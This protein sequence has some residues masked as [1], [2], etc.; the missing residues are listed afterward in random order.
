MTTTEDGSISHLGAAD[1]DLEPGE[2]VGE[3]VVSAK[4]GEGGFGSVFRAEHPLIGK[5]VAIK[6]L[7]RQYSADPAMVQRF[8]AEARAVNQIRHRNIID[9]FSFGRLPDGRH[10]YVME[11]LDG[12][13]LDQ[14]V[15]ER[16]RIPLPEAV[17]ILRGVARALDAAHAKGIAHR[18]L[19]PENVFLAVDEQGGV[20]PKLLD[21]GIAKLLTTQGEGAKPSFKTRTGAPIG[22][23]YYMSPEQCR[24]RDVDHRTDIYA[25]G[26]V[27][28]RMLTGIYPFDGA[29]YMEILIKQINEEPHPA[30][31]LA[32]E[33]PASVDDCIAWMLRK[34]PAQRPP[35]LVSAMSALEE[36]A[37]AAGVAIPAESSSS[38]IHAVPG[39]RLSTPGAV[40]PMKTPRTP[41][42]A[43]A[44]STADTLAAD[45]GDAVVPATAAPGRRGGGKAVAAVLALAVL[46]GGGFVAY[47]QL[48]G[49][50]QGRG[51]PPA[52][53]APAAAPSGAPA[54]APSPP[55][56]EARFVVIDVTGAPEGT[57]VLGP[58]GPIGAA[59][60]RIQLPRG[61]EK[62]LLTFRAPGH[63]PA[64]REVEP[65]AD[66]ALEVALEPLADEPV[67]A[68]GKKRRARKATAGD[69][70]AG[71]DTNTIEDPF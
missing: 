32:A 33:L 10:Y 34:D 48:G 46:G 45:S 5:Q 13:P 56:V 35:N 21:F 60:G 59:P 18:D 19:K 22:T 7:N 54:P 62:V 68:S 28:Y 14:Y 42:A 58:T 25:F 44:V 40:T 71:D 57:E 51:A 8:V 55:P 37:T 6:V 63:K 1:A 16:G 67:K 26:C 9:I 4:L 50:D 61:E 27:T 15:L 20:Y 66:G 3:Y 53:T 43:H 47:S 11:F 12:R 36:A 52:I 23:P 29:D 30:S 17:P 69:K 24:G 70:P 65:R 41:G 49:G 31:Q 39:G 38:A 64:T 2:K